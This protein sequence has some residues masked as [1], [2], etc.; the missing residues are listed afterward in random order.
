M[1]AAFVFDTDA[2][3][4]VCTCAICGE[5]IGVYERVLVIGED[6]ARATSLAREPHLGDDSAT[7]IHH[8]CA[9]H[10]SPERNQLLAAAG[11]TADR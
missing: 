10:V 1:A 7:V 6:S 2:M 5:A 4:D 8:S 11:L 9:S 3:H